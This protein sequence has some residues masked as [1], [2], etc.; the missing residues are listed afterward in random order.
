MIAN[1]TSGDFSAWYARCGFTRQA[2]AATALGCTPAAVSY[3]LS[4]ERKVMP[5]TVQACVMHEELL[6]F[7]RQQDEQAHVVANVAA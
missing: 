4:G 6:R 5:R 2:E 7:R 1:W 3:M